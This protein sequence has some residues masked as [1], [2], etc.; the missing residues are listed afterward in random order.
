[1]SDRGDPILAKPKK[2]QK[3]IK[4]RTTERTGRPVEIPAWL[5][6]LR[7]NLVD[8]EIPEQRDTHASSSHEAS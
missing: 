5:Q 3:P 7:E 1:M 6:E 4:K 8:D 2:I